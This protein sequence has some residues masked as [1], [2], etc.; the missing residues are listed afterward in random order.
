MKRPI[1]ALCPSY[2]DERVMVNRRYMDA[3]Q[4]SGG[5]PLL[6]NLTSDKEVIEYYANTADGFLFTGGDD[7]DPREFGETVH[8]GFGDFCVERDRMEIPLAKR[9][10][11][12]KKP[13]LGICRGIQSMNVAFGGSLYQDIPIEF[14]KKLIHRQNPP[15]N[16][17]TH[18]ISIKE[19]TL[20]QNI[21]GSTVYATNS[22]HHQSLKKV[23]DGFIVSAT[24]EDGIIEAFEMPDY[25]FAL[26]LQFHP[27][28]LFATDE[29]ARNIFKSFVAA[30]EKK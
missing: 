25:P 24:S 3:I 6:M 20:L 23:A 18:N 17:P 16:V 5:I 8:E 14:S 28:H 4:K 27:E 1:I 15:Y 19:G 10:M 30:C 7:V 9:V 29:K 26:G 12:L 21:I 2:D 11:E 22:M 13:M